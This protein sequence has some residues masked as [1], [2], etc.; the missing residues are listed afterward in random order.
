MFEPRQSVWRHDFQEE[1]SVI[2]C[3]CASGMRERD[4]DS[5]LHW[6]KLGFV[7]GNILRNF[8]QCRGV[9]MS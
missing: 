5:H 6:R 7:V 8:V 4:A 1:V 3:Q 2:K 9:W